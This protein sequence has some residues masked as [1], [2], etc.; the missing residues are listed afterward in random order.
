MCQK[1]N[2]EGKKA[3]SVNYYNGN[4]LITV[5]AREKSYCQRIIGS[6]YF[7]SFRCWN[8]QNLKK[9]HKRCA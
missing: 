8:N 5:K 6:P 3:V 4:N 9:W 2:F 1:I 7:T